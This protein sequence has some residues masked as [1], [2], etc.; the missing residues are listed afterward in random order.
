[1]G[2]SLS[3]KSAVSQGTT[4]TL[5]ASFAPATAADLPP[6]TPLAVVQPL[7]R[8]LHA[9]VVEDNDINQMVIRTY[10]EDMGHSAL[11]VG[12][13]EAAIAALQDRVFDVILM[14][15]NLPGQS[16]T[17][18]TRTIRTLVDRQIAELPIIGISA[19]VQEADIRENLAAGM[20]VVLAKPLSPEA[21]QTALHD[22]VPQSHVLFTLAK[23]IGPDRA[24]ALARLFLDSLPGNL[25]A[26]KAAARSADHA[27]LARIAHQMKG[28][29]GNFDLGPLVARLDRIEA[30]GALGA[31]AALNRCLED[32]PDALEE[33]RFAVE[34][35]LGTLDATVSQAAQ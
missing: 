9:L 34:A 32:L 15:V 35:A 24:T 11:V 16:G 29:A 21:L 25:T 10:L 14:D 17:A 3:V 7:T 1:M 13:A 4:F 5:V 27:A 23:D 33:A 30:L 31:S 20:S 2:A 6:E 26:L 18:A 22:Q 19:H 12:T 8:K 28:A